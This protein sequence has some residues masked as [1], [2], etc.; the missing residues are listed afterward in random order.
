[1]DSSDNASGTEQ[2]E[3]AEDDRHAVTPICATGKH[4]ESDRG[5]ADYSCNG[6]DGS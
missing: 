1:V 2:D 5:D 6:S 3:A 4:H